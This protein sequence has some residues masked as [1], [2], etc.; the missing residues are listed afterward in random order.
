M[1]ISEN[2]WVSVAYLSG[3]PDTLC[4]WLSSQRY[5]GESP[6]PGSFQATENVTFQEDHILAMAGMCYVKF[7]I[8]FAGVCC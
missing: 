2:P 1:A 3:P 5:L 4:L 8:N 6:Q 7:R